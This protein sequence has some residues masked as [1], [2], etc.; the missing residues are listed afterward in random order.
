[1][2]GVLQYSHPR[3]ARHDLLEHLQPFPGE[4]VLEDSEAGDVAARTREACNKAV[5][6]RISDQREHDRHGLGHAM[7]R[8]Q[9]GRACCHDHVR[10]ERG[11]FG[12][13]GAGFF[14]SVGGGEADIDL[15]VAAF[16]PAEPAHGIAKGRT[17]LLACGIVAAPTDP[18][19][20]V[21]DAAVLLRARRNRPRC[22]GAEKGGTTRADA[23]A[24]PLSYGTKLDAPAGSTLSAHVL[25][26]SSFL[27]RVRPL[28]KATSSIRSAP[29]SLRTVPPTP[30]QEYSCLI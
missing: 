27:R 26:M 1:M 15:D 2:I 30:T 16:R 19:H 25:A 21:A 29:R 13:G 22:R 6:D 9:N 28:A 10:I 17:A 23:S 18:D 8:P 7:Q 20:D 24:F 14:G 4:R 3:N 12:G 5:G 11:E